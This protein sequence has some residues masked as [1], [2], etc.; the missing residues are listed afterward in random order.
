MT[1]EEVVEDIILAS[2]PSKRFV[3]V[4]DIGAMAAFL[5]GPNASSFNGTTLTADGGWTAR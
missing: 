3:P 2:Q 1:E 4:T 5:A